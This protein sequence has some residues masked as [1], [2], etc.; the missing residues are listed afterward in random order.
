MSTDNHSNHSALAL[1]LRDVAAE[2]Q[3]HLTNAANMLI[4]GTVSNDDIM[5]ELA[6]CNTAF[7][8][9]TN[10]VTFSVDIIDGLTNDVRHLSQK[11]KDAAKTSIVKD[12]RIEDLKREIIA[13]QRELT[14]FENEYEHSVKVAYEQ[15]EKHGFE[16]ADYR[17]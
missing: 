3:Q 7:D 17:Q 5:T 9:L 6:A 11:L 4:E 16:Q 1:Q 12:R 8:T 14:H 13:L 10:T 2:G 15:G